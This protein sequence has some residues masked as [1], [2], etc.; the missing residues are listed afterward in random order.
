MTSCVS[1]CFPCLGPDDFEVLDI[2]MRPTFLSAR[3]LLLIGL[4]VRI[5]ESDCV[6]FTNGGFAFGD[7]IGSYGY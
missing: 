7:G 5:V 6:V 1:Y 2:F 3:F 4:F